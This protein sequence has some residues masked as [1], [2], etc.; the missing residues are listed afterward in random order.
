LVFRR[1]QAT[2]RPMTDDTETRARMSSRNEGGNFM[3]MI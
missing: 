1:S 2:F 3:G